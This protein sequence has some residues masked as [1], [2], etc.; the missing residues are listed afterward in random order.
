MLMANVLTR[1][2]PTVVG[3]LHLFLTWL[4]KNCHTNLRKIS[5]NCKKLR[6]QLINIFSTD[7]SADCFLNSKQVLRVQQ[8]LN[9]D[10]CRVIVFMCAAAATDPLQTMCF[11]CVKCCEGQKKITYIIYEFVN[12]KTDN[13]C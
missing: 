12:R 9:I 7:L 5:K 1:N 13:F 11:I 10:K 6:L 3:R 2:L 4:C 8:N